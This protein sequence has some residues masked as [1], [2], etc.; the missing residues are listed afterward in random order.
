MSISLKEIVIVDDNL[1][2]INQLVKGLEPFSAKWVV[3]GMFQ[4]TEKALEYFKKKRADLLFIDVQME[5]LNGFEFWARLNVPALPV[6]FVTNYE[7]YAIKAFDVAAMDFLIKPVASE[8]LAE[9]L[10]RVNQ[11]SNEDI[12]LQLE[13]LQ[14]TIQKIYSNKSNISKIIINNQHSVELV[15][16]D[17]LLW[18]EAKGPYTIF[19]KRS[20]KTIVATKPLKYYETLL[21]NQGF[22]RLHRSNMVNGIFAV[23]I[24]K[25]NLVVHLIDGTELPIS[26]DRLSQFIES[27]KVQMLRNG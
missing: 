14:E 4:D 19:Y 2:D 6:V 8:R 26:P 1:S 10:L 3:S 21:I 12:R 18:C 7:E 22:F 27:F 16:L 5:P 25:S 23:K 17:E 13:V 20:G 24:D 11:L 15:H 9:T